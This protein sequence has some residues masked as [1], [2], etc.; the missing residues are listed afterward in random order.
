MNGMLV[1]NEFYT[2]VISIIVFVVVVFLNIYLLSDKRMINTNKKSKLSVW[3]DKM[4]S[5]ASEYYCLDVKQEGKNYNISVLYDEFGTKN[6]NVYI[7]KTYKQYEDVCADII[8][9]LHMYIKK[10]ENNENLFQALKIEMSFEE[11]I[12]NIKEDEKWKEQAVF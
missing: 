12:F 1:I 5:V 6:N 8:K 4:F 11:E 10:A 7:L 2:T 3:F 9:E